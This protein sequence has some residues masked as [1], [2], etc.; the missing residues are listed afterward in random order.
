M[1]VVWKWEQQE[2]K[3]RL[4]KKSSRKISKFYK[5]RYKNLSDYEKQKLVENR[6]NIIERE[7]SFMIKS[8]DLKSSFQAKNLLQK[9]YLNKKR[10][11]QI[12]KIIN[13]I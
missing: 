8:N 3:E 12:K 5:N 11:K 1:F 9:G 2:N 7:N 10:Q 13:L 4:E 6:K